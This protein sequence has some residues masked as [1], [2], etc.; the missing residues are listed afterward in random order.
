MIYPLLTYSNGFS[1]W[2]SIQ[3]T[4]RNLIDTWKRMKKLAHNQLSLYTFYIG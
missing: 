4:F 2:I 3:R 1:R